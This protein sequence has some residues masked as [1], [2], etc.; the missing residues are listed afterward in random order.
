M[1]DRSQAI[2]DAHE[3]RESHVGWREWWVHVAEC[4]DEDCRAKAAYERNRFNGR[5]EMSVEGYAREMVA[6]EDR[7][8]AAYDNILAC[9]A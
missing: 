4:P 7:W 1:S 5:P 3:A 2:A 9:L 6:Y 8:I